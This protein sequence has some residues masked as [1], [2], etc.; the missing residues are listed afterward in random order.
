MSE[1]SFLLLQV[2]SWHKSS[3]STSWLFLR[4]SEFLS[5][6]G[7]KREADVPHQFH[8]CASFVND[9]PFLG[10]TFCNRHNNEPCPTLSASFVTDLTFISIT[11]VFLLR[12]SFLGEVFTDWLLRCVHMSVA[13][14]VC[15]NVNSMER[16]RNV[17]PNL[18][19]EEGAERWPL[20]RFAWFE[21]R[22]PDERALR[23]EQRRPEHAITPH[24]KWRGV[25]KL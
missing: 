14:V 12:L 20:S 1:F 2:W 17:Q 6:F 4:D 10:W 3:L 18:C 22:G 7:A 24:A 23:H 13:D 15:T 11:S 16:G 25:W 8:P 21:R 5:F 9:A 19:G